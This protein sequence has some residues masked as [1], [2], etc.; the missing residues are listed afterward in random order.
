MRRNEKICSCTV[1]RL[2]IDNFVIFCIENKIL[3]KT[4]KS[5]LL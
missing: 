2:N 5:G 3:N 4:L 1:K